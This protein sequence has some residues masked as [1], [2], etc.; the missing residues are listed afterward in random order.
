MVRDRMAFE[1][2]RARNMGVVCTAG[3]GYFHDEASLEA[4]VTAHV[5]QTNILADVYRALS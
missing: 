3:G 5:N 1:W 2:C 4:T